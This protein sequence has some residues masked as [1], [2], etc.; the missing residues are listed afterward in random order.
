[1]KK[2]ILL[3]TLFLLLA[4]FDYGQSV[5]IGTQVW[6]TK[7]LDVSTFRNG[8]PIPNAKTNEEWEN[9]GKN[10]QHAWCY[11]D[12]DSANGTKYGKLYNWYAV[13]DPRGLAPRGWHVPSEEEWMI[14]LDFLGEYTVAGNMM[15]SNKGWD[16]YQFIDNNG[17]TTAK[18][19]NGNNSSGFTGLP[20]GSRLIAIFEDLGK[21]GRWWSST[22]ASSTEAF[23]PY[24]RYDTYCFN[25]WFTF[26]DFGFSVRCIK[27]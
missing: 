2:L 6:S 14:L 19:I 23:S 4:F 1:M 18:S 20:G 5:T 3:S 16:E 10:K 11:Y 17:N 26:K 8:N 9:A 15:K 22:D 25:S 24:L 13:N 27:D 21:E 12:H 7:N